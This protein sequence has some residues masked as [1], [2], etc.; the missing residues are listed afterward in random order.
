MLRITM[1]SVIIRGRAT[2]CCF[3]V[4]RKRDEAGL[5]MSRTGQGCCI[6]I[7]KKPRNLAEKVSDDPVAGGRLHVCKDNCAAGKR[8]GVTE[9]CL[10]GRP[11]KPRR[12]EQQS[13]RFNSLNRSL[14]SIFRPY[15]WLLQVRRLLLRWLLLEGWGLGVWWRRL[16]WPVLLPVGGWGFRGGRGF[17]MHG[18]GGHG[19]RR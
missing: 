3:L 11:V 9:H 2:S 4:T 14:G 1:R 17:G 6:T 19:G 18:G 16:L 15:G 7:I 13:T 5:C 8:P 10:R 12:A